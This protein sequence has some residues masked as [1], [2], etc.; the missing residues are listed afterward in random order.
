MLKDAETRYSRV[1]KA[2]LSLVYAA[3]TTMT[4]FFGSYDLPHDEISSYT[5]T[6]ATS[7]SFRKASTIAPAVV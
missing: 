3:P 4:L 1:E 7:P 2:C 5:L 6:L